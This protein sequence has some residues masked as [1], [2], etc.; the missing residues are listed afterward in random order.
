[1][2]EESRGLMGKAL[3]GPGRY[4]EGVIAGRFRNRERGRELG[5][6]GSDKVVSPVSPKEKKRK[7]KREKGL[8]GW[9]VPGR[10]GDWLLSFFFLNLFHF[11]FLF[12]FIDFAYCIQTRSNHFLNFCK[13]HSK[14]LNQ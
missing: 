8:L 12:S 10:P 11:L 7:R 14:A 4:W 3:K 2:E 5:E 13:I 6:E 1:V 9:F